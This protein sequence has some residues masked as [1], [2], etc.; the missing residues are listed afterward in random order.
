[1]LTLETLLTPTERDQL[2]AMVKQATVSGAQAVRL[3]SEASGVLVVGICTGG[4]LLTWFATPAHNAIEADVA[5]SV[6]LA[7][8]AQASAAV[9]ALQTG[10]SDIAASA[11]AKAGMH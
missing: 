10:A 3:H 8:I 11:I 4:D 6:I 7:G 9:A 5:Q 1:M 2:K